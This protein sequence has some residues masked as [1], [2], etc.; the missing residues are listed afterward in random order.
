MI[1]KI[2]I[3]FIIYVNYI[4]QCNYYNAK[5]VVRYTAMYVLWL[6][7]QYLIKIIIAIIDL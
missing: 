2:Y 1:I 6:F 7:R 5:Y 3:Y 4:L